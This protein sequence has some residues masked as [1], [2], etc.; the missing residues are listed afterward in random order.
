MPGEVTFATAASIPDVPVP[1]IAR[2][3]APGPAPNVRVEPTA[4]VV[5]DH[6]HLGI[7]M[8]EDGRGHRPH[9]AS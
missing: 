4:H 8:A 2:L 5:E 9:H 1:E 6:H 7:E 3:N